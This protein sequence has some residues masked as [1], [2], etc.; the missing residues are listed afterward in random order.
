MIGQETGEFA[1]I[2]NSFE[3]QKEQN[4]FLNQ[5]FTDIQRV[6]IETNDDKLINSR[7]KKFKA[8][9]HKINDL[10]TKLNDFNQFNKNPNR[11]AE[12]RRYCT[13]SITH[14][15]KTISEGIS[16]GLLKSGSNSGGQSKNKTINRHF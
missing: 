6:D 10:Q 14:T 7:D 12:L 8:I 11:I 13:T 5:A 9:E 16:S 15:T 2:L 3:L 4:E 1:D